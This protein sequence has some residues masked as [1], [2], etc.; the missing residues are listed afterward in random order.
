MSGTIHNLSGKKLTLLVSFLLICQFVCFL[1]GGL[2]APIPSS[3]QTILGTICKDVP[4]SHNDTSVWLHSRGEGSCEQLDHSEILKDDL[5][6]ANRIV[7]VFQMPLPREGR[8]LDYSR[9]Q[10]NLIGILQT[11]IA[12]DPTI[13]NTPHSE[14]NIDSRLA[15]RNKEDPE[16]EWKYYASSLE[17]RDL[18]C[19]SDNFTDKYMYTCETIPLFELA[20]LHHD[21]YL[22]NV[23]IPVDS[24]RKMN[25]N[26]GY[27]LDLHLS[28]I[29]QN[30]GFTKVWVSLK[31]VFFPFIVGIMLWFWNRVHLLQRKPVL[32]EYMLIYLGAALTL[33]NFPFEYLTLFYEM[34]FMLLLSDLRQG[35]FYA[36]LCSFWLVFAGEHMLIQDSGER[37]S[38]KIYWKHLSAVVT[39]CISLFLFDMCERG[40]QIRNPFYSIWVSKFGSNV[41]MMFICLGGISAGIY[42]LFLCYMVWKVFSNISIKR[43]VLPSM[44]TVR[45]L[46]YEGIIYRFKFLML[47]TLLCALLTIVG[48]VLGQVSEGR[49]NVN[50][51]VELEFS[52]AFFTGVYGMWNIYIFALMILYAPSHKKWPTNETQESI[53]SEEI[54]FNQLPESSNPSEISS[55]TQFARK[56]AL[57]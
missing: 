4:G 34:K 23:R 3:V 26:I 25:L 27:I 50:E 51:N 45:R 15:F 28:V 37:N 32:L 2:V 57:D 17:K 6:M 21:Y 33:L 31:T 42:F 46:H 55:L 52:S 19:W 1:I 47:A 30:G 8:I 12:N 9:W 49:W 44:S 53:I 39:G 20:A 10:Q 11:D 48:F 56:A 7:F 41:A 13:Y 18:D 40:V 16:N 14:I 35:V 38:L 22:L 24:D 5:R 54:E 36:M 29:Y 43:S